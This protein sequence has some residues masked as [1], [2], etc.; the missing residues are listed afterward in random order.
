MK[1]SSIVPVIILLLFFGVNM[2]VHAQAGASM[3]YTIVV[4]ENNM[5]HGDSYGYNYDDRGFNMP[6]NCTDSERVLDAVKEASDKMQAAINNEGVKNIY[7]ME[8]NLKNANLFANVS[9]RNEDDR[10]AVI[11]EYN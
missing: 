2:S 6:V 10:L 7:N 1:A 9:I 4:V 5:E 3:S 11:I 8:K